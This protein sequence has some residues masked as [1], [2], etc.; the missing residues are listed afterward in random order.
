MSEIKRI[1]VL[2]KLKDI[3]VEWSR[4]LWAIRPNRL[5]GNGSI[6]WVY[7]CNNNERLIG[8][9]DTKGILCDWQWPS[10]LWW[11]STSSLKRQ[12]FFRR[13]MKDWP[14]AFH[15]A[16]AIEEASVDVSFIIGHR[17]TDRLPNL[18][19]TLQSIVAQQGVSLECIIVEQAV[20]AEIRSAL[21][22]WV[23]YVHTP[24]PDSQMPYSRS[25]AFN[26]GAR[27]ARSR[28]L[29]F[30]DND[31]CVPIDY[32]KELLALNNQGY[33]VM[34]LQRFVIYLDEETSK[35]IGE[36]SRIP[37]SVTP[38]MFLQNCHGGTI[39]VDRTTF[40]EIG[41]FDEGFIGWGGED[42][43]FFQRC[44]TTQIYAYS[45]LPFIHLY[46]PPQSRAHEG[47]NVAFLEAC[48]ARPVQERI[49][50]LAKRDFGNARQTDPP[51]PTTKIK[52]DQSAIHA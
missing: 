37:K 46:H 41:G 38:L 17:G 9:S 31:L 20:H 39:A 43:E 1:P 7:Y 45:Y 8:K 50:E 4:F 49:S 33:R 26:I 14:V 3:T 25:W 32:S 15:D 28:L 19:V 18:L 27:A 35:S 52:N 40:F 11:L 48:L 29:I 10:P 34:R 51:Y 47:D 21:P 2:G 24:P 30:H 16:P 23:R 44:R 6:P 22:D 13:V 42:D 5:S 12:S 36:E